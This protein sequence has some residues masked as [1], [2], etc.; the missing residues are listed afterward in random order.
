VERFDDPTLM[1][2]SISIIVPAYNEEKTIISS[3]NSFL[4]NDYPNLEVVVVNDGSKDYTLEMLRKRFRLIESSRGV[5]EQLETQQVRMTYC[6]IEEPRLVV[7]D[8]DNGGKADALNAGINY[9]RGSLFCAVDADSIIEMDALR[10]LVRKYLDRKEKIVALGGIVRIANGCAIQDGKVQKV[11]LPSSALASF[12]VIE[13]IRA[14]LCGR[15]GWNKL[16]ILIIISGAFGLFERKTVIKAGG[17][18]TNTVG[19]DME[20]V[21]RLHRYMRAKKQD[22]KAYFLPDPVCWTEVPE[23]RRVLRT[24]RRRWQRGLAET[25]RAHKGMICNPRYGMIGLVGMPYFLLFELLGPVIETTGYVVVA[26]SFIFGLISLEVFLL[27][28]M[29]SLVI[30]MLLSVFS[31]LMEEFTIKRYQR[32]RDVLKLFVFA[33]LE[34][35]GYRQLNSWWRLLGLKDHIKKQGSWGSME[36]KG[37]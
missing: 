32:K 5:E 34:N 4:E 16:N 8:K 24:Q 14:F 11:G 18:L 12:Q 37:L 31:L 36:R 6:S 3:V 22:Y 21:V 19:E 26:C 9:A 35:F 7:V 2:P 33:L 13:Y 27:F 20:L 10:K 29:L 30:G 1:Y 28:V 25:M 17:Y 23:T 15:V